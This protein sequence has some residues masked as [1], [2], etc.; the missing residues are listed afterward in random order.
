MTTQARTS[1][2]NH[3]DRRTATGAPASTSTT[4]PTQRLTYAHTCTHAHTHRHT[5]AHLR[6]GELPHGLLLHL[7]LQAV[8][9]RLCFL[10]ALSLLCQFVATL[11]RQTLGLFPLLGHLTMMRQRQSSQGRAGKSRVSAAQHSAGRSGTQGG[12]QARQTEHAHK[13]AHSHSHTH[14]HAHTRADTHTH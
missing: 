8:G 3:K 1:K 13:H 9:A 2:K 12:R 4:T 7:R 14:T 5:L 10:A 6:G 11:R